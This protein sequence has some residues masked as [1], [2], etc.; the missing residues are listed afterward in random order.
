MPAKTSKAVQD[1]ADEMFGED[2]AAADVSEDDFDDL[3][4]EVVEDDSEGW[5]PAEKGDSIAGTV[6]KVGTTNSDFAKPGEDPRV[7]TVTIQNA[8]GKFRVIGY[9]SVLRREMLDHN[10]RIGDKFAVKFFGER[11]LRKGKFAG[12]PYRHFGVAVRRQPASEGQPSLV[13]AMSS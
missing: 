12:K 9:G 10:P 4:D 2:E 13:E 3:L 1:E 7:P 6:V 8:D 5:V 11:P